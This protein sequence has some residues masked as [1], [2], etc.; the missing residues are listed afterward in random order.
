MMKHFDDFSAAFDY[1]RRTI[2]APVTVWVRNEKVRL[3]PSGY[4]KLLETKPNS[5]APTL[6][7][8]EYETEEE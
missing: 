1:C 4:A 3:F 8:I 7:G 6:A 5:P 2:G